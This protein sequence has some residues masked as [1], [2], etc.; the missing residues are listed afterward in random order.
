L[1][2]CRWNTIIWSKRFNFCVI[3]LKSLPNRFPIK[4]DSAFN[5]YLSPNRVD[6][7]IPWADAVPAIERWHHRAGSG[8]ESWEDAMIRIAEK[9]G[10]THTEMDRY[11][12]GGHDPWT[13]RNIETYNWSKHFAPA[14]NK[15]EDFSWGIFDPSCISEAILFSTVRIELSGANKKGV[16]TGF[17]YKSAGKQLVITNKHVFN[18]AKTAKLIFHSARM[19][20]DGRTVPTGVLYTHAV[21]N[22]SNIVVPHP[23]DDTDLCAILVDPIAAEASTQKNLL[24]LACSIVEQMIPEQVTLNSMPVIQDVL[25]TVIHR[26]MGSIQQLA[27]CAEGCFG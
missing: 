20:D 24:Y 23:D 13:T 22:L 5:R 26:T 19:S 21:S 12:Q 9:G 10:F 4:A 1:D 18:D 25:C 3:E 17:L 16:A 14:I 27:D 11:C 8:K 15:E 6:G 2:W 7:S